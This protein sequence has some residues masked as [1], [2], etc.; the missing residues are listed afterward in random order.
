MAGRRPP[1]LKVKAL[2]WL[3]QREHSRAELRAR[4]LRLLGEGAPADEAKVEPAPD[5]A[6]EVDTLLDWLEAHRYLSDT[7]FAESRVQVRAA[8]F[9]NLRIQGELRQHGV[10]LTPADQQALRDSEL[11][12]A[13]DVWR[14]KFGGEPATDAAGRVKQMRFLSGRGFSPEVVRRVIRSAGGDA[15]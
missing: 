11:A 7:R 13:Q 1:S 3:A 15:D 14:R 8:R 10:A 9:G 5:P 2:Q 4:L 12:R 6:A